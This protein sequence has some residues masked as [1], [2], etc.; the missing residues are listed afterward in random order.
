MK[1][2]G[3]S[4]LLGTGEIC[5]DIGQACSLLLTCLFQHVNC[6]YEPFIAFLKL[7]SIQR[8][9]H[10]QLNVKPNSQGLTS[11]QSYIDLRTLKCSR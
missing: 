8:T 11:L 3:S 9:L 5:I 2:E 6:E 10:H 4:W 1:Q 7:L